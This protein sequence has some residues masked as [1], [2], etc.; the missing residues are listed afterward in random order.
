MRLGDS[1]ARELFGSARVARLA[2]VGPDAAPHLVPVTFAVE[3]DLIFTA[4]DFKP[5]STRRLQRLRN[6]ADNPRTAVLADSYSEDWAALWWV[7][8]DG[9][10]EVLTDSDAMRHPIDVLVARYEQYQARRPAGPVIAI[11]AARWSGWSAE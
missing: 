10:A 2:T 9:C 8:V 1:E 7:R 4:V 5:K 11:R 3:G 6:L